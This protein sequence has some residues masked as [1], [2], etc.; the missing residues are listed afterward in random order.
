M[1]MAVHSDDKDG[2]SHLAQHH[3]PG[4]LVVVA[5]PAVQQSTLGLWRL[6]GQ[7]ILSGF[8]LLHAHGRIRSYSGCT[9][10]ARLIDQGR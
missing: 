4:A 6:P 1:Q 9:L 10:V 5:Y 8:G 7:N 2:L 3:N